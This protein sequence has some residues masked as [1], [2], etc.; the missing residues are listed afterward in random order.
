MFE[1]NPRI[2]PSHRKGSG[3]GNQEGREKDPIETAK[4]TANNALARYGYYHYLMAQAGNDVLRL[5]SLLK[6]PMSEVLLADNYQRDL[7]YTT[8]QVSAFT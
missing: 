8:K 6:L 1:A 5:Q 3:E 4:A 7:D 2:F